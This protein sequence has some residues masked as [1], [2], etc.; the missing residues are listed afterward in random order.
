MKS[1]WLVLLQGRAMEE[2]A[3]WLGIKGEVAYLTCQLK[4]HGDGQ[5]AQVKPLGISAVRPNTL[6]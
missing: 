5:A 6:G 1:P 2:A 4:V 3:A